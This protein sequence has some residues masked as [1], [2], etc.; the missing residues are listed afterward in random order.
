MPLLFFS[1]HIVHVSE[2]EIK[3]PVSGV[4]PEGTELRLAS[5][6]NRD[7]GEDEVE[8]RIQDCGGEQR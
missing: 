4:R 3:C 5:I 7:L 2:F 8:Q 6:A 1:L